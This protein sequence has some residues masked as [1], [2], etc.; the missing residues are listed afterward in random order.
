MRAYRAKKDCDALGVFNW[1]VAANRNRY[2]KGQAD[3]F[4]MVF[5]CLKPSNQRTVL[6]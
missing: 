1:R 3:G 2:N 5:P 6:L 4:A